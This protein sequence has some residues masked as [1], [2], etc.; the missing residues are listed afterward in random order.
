MGFGESALTSFM[1]TCGS[2]P[3]RFQWRMMVVGVLSRGSRL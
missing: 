3:R 2:M 1:V